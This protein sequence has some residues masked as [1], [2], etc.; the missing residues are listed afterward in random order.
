M[1]DIKLVSKD[2]RSFHLSRESV[3]FKYEVIYN[4]RDSSIKYLKDGKEAP[5]TDYAL[6]K[7]FKPDSP[8]ESRQWNSD[9]IE[10]ISTPATKPLFD[11]AFSTYARQGMEWVSKIHRGLGRLLSLTAL[12][13]L[14]FSGFSL[15]AIR[16][17]KFDDSKTKP[18]DIL[19][20]P[21]YLI[22]YLKR[23]PILSWHRVKCLRKMDGLV[24][25]NNTKVFLEVLH[26]EG[27][28]DSF[29]N[30][31]NIFFELM[32]DYGYKDARKL[33]LYVGRDVKLQQG[34]MNMRDAL[35]YLRD[36]NRMSRVMGY[37]HYDR[38]TKNLKKDHDVTSMNYKVVGSAMKNNGFVAAVQ[39]VRYSA[40]SHKRPDYSIVLPSDIQSVIDEGSSLSHCVASYVDDII[41]GKCKILFMRETEAED[42]PFV[43]I[44]VREDKVRQVRGQSNR[45]PTP[46]EMAYVSRWAEEKELTVSLY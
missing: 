23:M 32:E 8:Y 44:E 36:Y 14:Y 42:K 5:A 40:L 9:V 27:L 26:D 37:P 41:D 46:N 33:L 29:F 24:G 22:P 18:V 3:K 38:Y 21:K 28:S 34:I 10:L 35:V 12:Q 17:M 30:C 31:D 45:R 1:G 6:D 13:T 2:D 11:F 15:D 19:G 25:G 4:F 20:V 43:T 7:F 16:G 39:A